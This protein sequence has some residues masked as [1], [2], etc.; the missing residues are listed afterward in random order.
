MYFST[1]KLVGTWKNQEDVTK[2]TVLNNAVIREK[3]KETKSIKEL[4]DSLPTDLLL[5]FRNAYV[6]SNRKLR[7]HILA[8]VIETITKF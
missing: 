5:P 7:H 3:E 2:W 1:I 8:I 6:Q 4:K